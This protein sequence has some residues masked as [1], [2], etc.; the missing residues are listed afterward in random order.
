MDTETKL[1][2]DAVDFEEFKNLRHAPAATAEPAEKAPQV[3]EASPVIAAESGAAEPIPQ[4]KQEAVEQSAEDKIKELRRQGKHNQANEVLKKEAARPHLEEIEKLRK[5]LEALRSRPS[6][7]VKQPEAKP[8][9]VPAQQAVDT[10]DP[11]PKVTD[12]KYAG[13]DGFTQYNRDIAIWAFRQETRKEQQKQAAI[14]HQRKAQ[15]ILAEGAKAK[16]D[17]QSVTSNVKV[18]VDVLR[19]AIED[20]PNIGDVLY[21]IGGDPA[22]TSRIANLS[23]TKQYAELAYLSRELAKPPVIAVKPPEPLKTAVSKVNAPPR[24]L[25]GADT[26]EPKSTAEA[27]DFDEFKRLRRAKAS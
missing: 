14:S 11:E 9:V 27:R 21:K 15:N 26:P 3:E 17:F 24:V 2:A 1:L 23:P 4:E 20:L 6:E 22:E 18:A 10:S 16:P 8:A 19:E 25:S 7:P 5:E 12:E 13:A